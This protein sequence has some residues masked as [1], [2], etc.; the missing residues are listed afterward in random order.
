MNGVAEIEGCGV[1]MVV[2]FKSTH[3]IGLHLAGLR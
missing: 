2:C 3:R 1:G